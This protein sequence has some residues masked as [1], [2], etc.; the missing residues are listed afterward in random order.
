VL[1]SYIKLLFLSGELLG[2]R[3]EPSW[4]LNSPLDQTLSGNKW[5]TFQQRFIEN[6]PEHVARHSYDSF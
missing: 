3:I 5:T 1:A 2:E 6:W 4:S